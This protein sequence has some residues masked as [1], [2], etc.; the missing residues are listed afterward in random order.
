[1]GKKFV[2]LVFILAAVAMISSFSFAECPEGKNEVLMVTPSGIQKTLCVP[3]T[4]IKGIE[5]AAEH[6]SSSIVTSSCLCWTQGD[7]DTITAANELP[8]TIEQNPYGEY[9]Y[10]CLVNNNQYGIYLH[11]N[12]DGTITCKNYLVDPSVTSKSL[13]SADYDTCASLL[14]PYVIN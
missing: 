7:L 13:S 10:S 14:D 5:T 11:Y 1:M 9:L 12:Y 8:C 3:D 6:S 2:G 4:A